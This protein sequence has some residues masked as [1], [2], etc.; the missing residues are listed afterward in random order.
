MER[1]V[2]ITGA[3]TGFGRVA[4]ERFARRGHHVFATMR[5]TGGR[6]AEAAASLE[7]MARAERL[8]LEVLDVDVTDDASVRRGVEQMMERAGRV[9]VVINNAGIAALGVT[10]AFTPEQFQQ[11]FDVNV[12]GAIRVNRAVLPA[13]RRQRSG[14]LIHVSSG[15]GRCTVPAMAPYCASKYALE[16]L[17]DALRYELRSLGIDSVLVEPGIYPTPILERDRL[18]EPA[19]RARVDDYGSA[20]EYP[21]RV[22]GVFRAAMSAP[23]APDNGEVA[24]VFVRLAEM[25]Q[26]LRPFRTLVSAPMEQ[27]LGGYNA[28]ADGLR[29]MVAQMFNVPELADPPPVV[30]TAGQ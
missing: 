23:D 1:V 21:A 25:P 27:L 9:D 7:E 3:S 26:G 14:L 13:M 6:N 11:V 30:R 4:A 24:D 12:S 5:A 28:T 16:A 19:D 22:L 15:A 2:F 10:E 18:I 17:A 20:G 8:R 29:S